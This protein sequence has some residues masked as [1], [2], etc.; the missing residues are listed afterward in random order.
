MNPDVDYETI[1]LIETDLLSFGY[2]TRNIDFFLA[3]KGVL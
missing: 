3:W 1:F 2:D